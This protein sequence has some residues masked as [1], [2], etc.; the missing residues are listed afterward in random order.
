LV[1][2]Y[3]FARTA[4][5]AMACLN[6]YYVVI[7]IYG[8]W[9]WKVAPQICR[10]GKRTALFCVLAI[11]LLFLLLFF[12]LGRFTD[13][14]L[15]WAD[16]LITS[17][18]VVATWMLSRSYLEQWWIWM[19]ANALAIGVYGWQGL[20]PT[21]ILYIAYTVAAVIGLNRWKGRVKT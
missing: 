21:A 18:S 6:V 9:S 17:M 13:A 10:I 19:A 4:F 2:I 16:A 3:V 12:I 5:Y 20:Y 7:S 1:Y 8:L 15:P 14:P 11:M